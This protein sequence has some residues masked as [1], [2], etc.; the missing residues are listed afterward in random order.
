MRIPREKPNDEIGRLT[1]TLNSM[2]SRIERAYNELEET[3]AAQRRFVSDASHE[4]RTPLTTIRGNIDLL[5]K[6]WAEDG[7][8]E[9]KGTGLSP[10][11]RKT[12]SMEAIRDIA[13]EARR[14]SSLVGDLLSLARADAGYRMEMQPIPLRQLAEEAARRASFLPRKA[15]WHVGP[16]DDLDGVWVNGNRDYLLQLLFILIENGFKYTPSGEVRLFAVRGE[17]RVGLVVADT[18]IGIHPED[19]PH[20]FD[21]FYRA[22]R[23]RGETSGTGLG[24]S[25]AKWIAN[26]HK[27]SLEVQSLPGQGTVFTLW[28]PVHAAPVEGDEG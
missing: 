4:L 21:R 25:I 19:L 14:M 27:G 28:L 11:E 17:N 12:M 18:G 8:E 16:L 9:R 5:Q 1:D 15:E 6:I 10:E 22:D 3:N 13:D 2:L 23:S 24:L 7:A 26:M 20:I